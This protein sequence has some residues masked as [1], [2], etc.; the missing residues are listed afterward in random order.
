MI[1]QDQSEIVTIHQHK[2]RTLVHINNV[3]THI[4]APQTMR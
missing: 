4:S 1:A 3:L 2:N